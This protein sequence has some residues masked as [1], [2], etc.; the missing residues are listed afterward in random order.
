MSRVWSHQWSDKKPF[1]R[2]LRWYCAGW[3]D[4]NRK[5]DIRIKF[6]DSEGTQNRFYGNDVVSAEKDWNDFKAGI[7][8]T[9]DI[10]TDL[11]L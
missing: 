6:D 3:S 1:T 2:R 9:R 10:M 11:I 5:L 8:T 7:L 4:E